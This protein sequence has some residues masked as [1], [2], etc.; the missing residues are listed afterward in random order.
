MNIILNKTRNSRD[1]FILVD[2]GMGDGG[3]PAYYPTH[4]FCV[5]NGID[6]GNGYQGYMS[7][8]YALKECSYLPEE[9]KTKLINV[10][11]SSFGNYLR[12]I[13]VI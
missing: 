13:G 4:D 11:R 5:V 1:R 10:L 7:I 3:D 9:V 8:T 12:E 6:R 2:G